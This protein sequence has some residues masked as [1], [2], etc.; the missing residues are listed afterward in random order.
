MRREV[1]ETKTGL[2]CIQSTDG[3][4]CLTST[5]FRHSITAL[6]T[7][8]TTRAL[9]EQ[10]NL[11]KEYSRNGVIVATEETRFESVAEVVFQHTI[12]FADVDWYV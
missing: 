9:A 1:D 7:E 10:P 4:V 8:I 6:L 11:C 3:A 5:V 2:R 12:S